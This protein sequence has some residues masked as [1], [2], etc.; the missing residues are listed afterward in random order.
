MSFQS[1]FLKVARKIRREF[2]R[3]FGKIKVIKN[4]FS[5]LDELIGKGPRRPKKSPPEMLDI[6]KLIEDHA[7]KPRGVI[8]IGANTASE[9]EEYLSMGF[10]KILY[11]EANPEL[12][13]ELKKKAARYPGIVFIVH[14]AVTDVDGLIKLR[15]TSQNQSSSILALGKHR[16]I[17]PSI[18]EVKQVEV[19]ARKLDTLLDEYG[20]RPADYNFLNI[21]IQGAELLALRGSIGLLPFVDAINTEVNLL[22][23]YKGCAMLNE[24]EDFLASHHFNRAAMATPW[25]HSWGDAFF[26]R[27][28]VV[29]MDNLGNN[30]SFANQLFQYMFLRLVAK[31][32]GAIVQTPPWVGQELFGFNDPAPLRHLPEWEEPLI[33]AETND[34]KNGA[35][36]SS[37][38]FKSPVDNFE[39]TNF[40]GHFIGHTLDLLPEQ[41]FIRKLFGFVPRFEE[42]GQQ[43][44]KLLRSQKRFI[45]AVHLRRGDYGY[46][47]FYRT[48]CSWYERWMS[49]NGLNPSEWIIYICSETPKKYRKRF[50]GYETTYAAD[51][52]VNAKLA[53]YFDFYIMTQADYVLTANST[54]SF[55]ASMLNVTAQGFARPSLREE[56]LINFNPWNAAVLERQILSAEEHDKLKKND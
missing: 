8:H 11:I 7:I 13:P 10:K 18:K 53:A 25:H 46:G 54:Y 37:I 42:L 22:E 16:E 50:A 23:L 15:V 30:G 5:S 6:K 56:K 43:K 38:Y 34:K 45:M 28:P 40:K 55:M 27:K 19:P 47:F 35:E 9:L 36:E 12:I 26:V 2:L 14:A 3:L 1:E 41:D 44:L 52:G 17:Y 29:S 48:P 21:D 4:N 32:Q 24:L 31:K 49:E 51:I 20:H 39:S 33:T